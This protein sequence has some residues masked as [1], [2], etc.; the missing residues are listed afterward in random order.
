LRWGGTEDCWLGVLEM[1]VPDTAE[2]KDLADRLDGLD[3]E[4]GPVTSPPIGWLLP[5]VHDP[6]GHEMLF[7]V[8]ELQEV[9][10]PE[11]RTR[12]HDA[13]AKGRT[14]KLARIDLAEPSV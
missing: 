7:Y 2:L 4:H 1:G 8:S 9:V 10:D 13:G 3:V 11:P 14:E 5:K 12:I 6:D